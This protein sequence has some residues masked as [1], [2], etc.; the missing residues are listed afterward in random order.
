[1]RLIDIRR[2]LE[3]GLYFILAVERSTKQLR[4]IVARRVRDR[5]QSY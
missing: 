2:L 1:M 4:R 3:R 5:Q